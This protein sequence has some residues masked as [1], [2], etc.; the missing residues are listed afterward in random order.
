MCC[1]RVY[2]PS[3]QFSPYVCEDKLFSRV[4]ILGQHPCLRHYMANLFFVFSAGV[5]SQ[6]VILYFGFEVSAK[7]N[8]FYLARDIEMFM[9]MCLFPP[10]AGPNGVQQQD[11][12]C[13]LL[14][15]NYCSHMYC[16]TLVLFD[17]IRFITAYLR[18]SLVCPCSR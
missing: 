11:T 14:E 17:W 1:D 2:F 10:V 3:F 16:Y 5:V 12:H 9:P 4:F 15:Y 8:V 18:L 7:M 6:Q 13:V